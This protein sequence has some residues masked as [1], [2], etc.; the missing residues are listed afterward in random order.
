MPVLTAFAL[1]GWMISV[2]I[3]RSSRWH[4]WPMPCGT[5][6]VVDQSSS[7]LSRAQGPRSWRPNKSAGAPSASNSTPPMSTSPSGDGSTFTS[8][9][10]VLEVTGETF[11]ELAAGRSYKV[12]RAK[13]HAKAHE[14]A[15]R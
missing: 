1:A 9:D 8:R 15:R 13:R 4:L 12:L 7:T 3:Q 11:D 6:R 14:A 10:A 2:Y 5:A